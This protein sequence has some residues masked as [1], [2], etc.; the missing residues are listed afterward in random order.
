MGYYVSTTNVSFNIPYPNFEAA[1]KAMCELNTTHDHLKRGGSYS[2]GEQKA[3]WF[4]WM[5]ANYPETC[6]TMQD[7]LTEVGFDMV[8]SP[9]DNDLISVHYDNKTGQEELFLEA[10]APFVREGSYIEW[11]GEDGA[12]WRNEFRDGKMYTKSGV[13][14]W[15]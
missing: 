3:K 6:K 4:S 15:K 1:Y 14:V 5:D 9:R 7:V 10:L 2:G 8:F 13:T 12:K 11:N